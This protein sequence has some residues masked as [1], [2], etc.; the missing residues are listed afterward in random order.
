M[1]RVKVA[2]MVEDI[3]GCKWS[4]RLL[5]LL[6]EQ[7]QRPSAMRRACRGLSAKVLHQ[8]LA[9]FLR[10]GLVRRHV[11]GDKPPV[12]VDYALTDL[13]GRFVVLLDSIAI[14]QRD[15][16]GGYFAPQ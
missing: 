5:A 3:V 10:F 2:A 11:H 8:R 15:L 7:P 13:G 14:L 9:K 1:E 16:D 12:E 6:R 4:L